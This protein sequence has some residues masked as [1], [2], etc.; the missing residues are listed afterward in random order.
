M[1]YNPYK[2]KFEMVVKNNQPP[3][4]QIL[5]CAVN[6]PQQKLFNLPLSLLYVLKYSERV[7]CSNSML[8]NLLIIFLSK[9][10]PELVEMID[11]HSLSTREFL[12]NV[13]Y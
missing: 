8:K 2:D 12:K 7:G 5:R 4:A 11:P 13:S 1:G 3:D 9:H 6:H 10:Q